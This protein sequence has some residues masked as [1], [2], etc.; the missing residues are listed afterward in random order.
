[1]Q[2]TEVEQQQQKNGK[3][4]YQTV[5]CVSNCEC[6]MASRGMFNDSARVQCFSRGYT[7]A[8]IGWTMFCAVVTGLWPRSV[9]SVPFHVTRPGK[10]PRQS[11]FVPSGSVEWVCD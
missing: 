8:H 10:D 7:H 4:T 3:V 6:H 2:L 5:S 1:M 9:R 11:D